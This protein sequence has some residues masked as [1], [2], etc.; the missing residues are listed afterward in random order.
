MTTLTFLCSYCGVKNPSWGEICH[1]VR[2]LDF[3]L[4][5]CENSSF[6]DL[7][8]VGDIVTGLKGFIVKFMIQMSRVRNNYS[9]LP[10]YIYNA[11]VIIGFFYI[12]VER[13]SGY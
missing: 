5:S 10:C 7:N 3:Q 9:F 1:F 11:F 13:R 6:T 12:F 4:E 8:L 2:F